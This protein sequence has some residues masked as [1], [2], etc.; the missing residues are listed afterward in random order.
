MVYR[1]ASPWTLTREAL[2][3]ALAPHR[4]AECGA[5]QEK[6]VGW[7]EPRGES[8]GDLVEVVGGQWVLKLAIEVKTVPG[9]VIKRKVQSEVDH[10]EATTG[11]KPGKKERRTLAD[12]ARMAL[13]PLAFSKQSATTVWINPKE[14]WM[15]LDAASQAKADEV[16]T[17]MVK[18]IDGFSV[19]LLQTQTSPAVSMAHWLGSKEA[20]AGFSVDRECELKASDESKAVVRYTRHPLDTDEVTQ[21]IAAGK[22]PTR[23]ALTWND[24]VSFVLTEALTLKKL[25]YLDVVLEEGPRAAGDSSDDRFDADV[26]IATGELMRMLPALIDALGGEVPL[27]QMPGPL[28]A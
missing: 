20:P 10:I 15:V 2:E 12:D 17:A 13:L 27:G 18:A 26:A 22:V 14:Q 5:S 23:L 25:A 7:T 1:L 24:R 9:S 6:S 28:A 11:R 21:H 19:T 4:F 3:K 8:H 16:L